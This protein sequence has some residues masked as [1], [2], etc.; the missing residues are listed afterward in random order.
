MSVALDHLVVAA[1]SLAAIRLERRISGP[2]VTL[3]TSLT[4]MGVPP[5]ALRTSCSRSST[6]FT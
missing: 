2:M 3:A 5:S 6:F 1:A 4:V